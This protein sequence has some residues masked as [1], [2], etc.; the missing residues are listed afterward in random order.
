M[1][2]FVQAE[3]AKITQETSYSNERYEIHRRL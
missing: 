2:A 3:S 1:W